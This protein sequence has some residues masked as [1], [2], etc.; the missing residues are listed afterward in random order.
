MFRITIPTNKRYTGV[1]A[2]VPF[3]NGEGKTK[4]SWKADWFKENKYKVEEI[5]EDKSEDYT[6]LKVDQLKEIAKEK[7]IT[8]YSEMN[9]DDL[10]TAIQNVGE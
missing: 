1:V 3:S 6:K 7:G 5:K 4:D 9:K 8:G 10:I 2:G